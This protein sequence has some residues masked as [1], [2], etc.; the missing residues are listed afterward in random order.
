[1]IS[2]RLKIPKN[3][4]FIFLVICLLCSSV[5]VQ[6]QDTS[7]NPVYVVQSGDTL[8][9]IAT[10]F[11]V[12]VTDL[13]VANNIQNPDILTAG[14]ELIIP[15]LTGVSGK[16][17]TTTVPLGY[18]L[19][20]ISKEYQI[21]MNLLTKLN[22]ITSPS[23]VYAGTN[24]IIPQDQKNSYSPQA[25]IAPLESLLD[26]SVINGI[27]PWV[28]ADTNRLQGVWDLPSGSL[29][30]LP[31]TDKSEQINTISPWIK[32]SWFIIR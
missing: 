10:R 16:L 20:S 14:T 12:S 15:G 29:V 2:L 22:R 18:S 6:A 9:V 21:S 8:N 17:V 32:E 28:V 26:I 24:L 25:E 7:N 23:E 27:N 31:A 5:P 1:V 4:F 19:D 30:Y 3:T 11:G 13:I